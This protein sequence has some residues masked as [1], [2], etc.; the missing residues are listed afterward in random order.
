MKLL[1]RD[2]NNETIDKVDLI[3]CVIDNVRLS[4]NLQADEE[5]GF[6]LRASLYFF[7]LKEIKDYIKDNYY[8]IRKTEEKFIRSIIVESV[9]F[10]SGLESSKDF[11]EEVQDILLAYKNE[12]ATIENFKA[13]EY[14]IKDLENQYKESDKILFMKYCLQKYFSE[15]LRTNMKGL[16]PNSM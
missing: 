12:P 16:Y 8:E 5:V 13:L 1:K 3:K 10:L 6:M 15:K 2:F 11:K 14:K 9:N 4:A 7:D